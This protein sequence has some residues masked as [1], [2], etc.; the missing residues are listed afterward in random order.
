[1]AHF[2]KYPLEPK[3]M[4]QE[5]SCLTYLCDW[6]AYDTFNS[7]SSSKVGDMA[8]II[9]S[10][11]N[12]SKDKG[13][14]WTLND[15]TDITSR[16]LEALS[17]SMDPEH[18]RSNDPVQDIYIETFGRGMLRKDIIFTPLLVHQYVARLNTSAYTPPIDRNTFGECD[19][20]ICVWDETYT[21]NQNM[22][23]FTFRE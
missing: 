15:A 21:T 14:L 23:D 9:V 5:V 12:K 7:F 8:P 2:E 22:K 6:H 16:L 10:T 13:I 17:Q 3:K 4:V 18:P 11:R 1:M 19:G 20:Q